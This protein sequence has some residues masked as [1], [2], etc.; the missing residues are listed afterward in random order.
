[1]KVINENE[2]SILDT[3][4]RDGCQ[5][6][7]MD[8]NVKKALRI[9][10]L[11]SRLGSRYIEMGFAGSNGSVNELI[12]QALKLK[13]G[14]TKIAA[15]GRT[16][17]PK[18]RVS[19]S[20]DLMS[21]L[22]LGV[23]VSVIVA[24][25]RLTDVKNSLGISGNENLQMIQDTILYLKKE[26]LEVIVDLEH[27]VDAYCGRGK[28]GQIEAGSSANEKYFL[29]VVKVVVDSGADIITIC[30]TNG[31]G[32][33]E[34]ASLMIDDLVSLYPG[35]NFG[36]HAHN[37]HDMAPAITRAAV[38]SGAKHI[39]GVFGGY[40]ERCG[41]A[42]LFSVIPRLQLKDGIEIVPDEALKIFTSAS[43][44][45]ARAFNRDASERAAFVGSNAF[46]TFAGMHG[47]SENKDKGAYTHSDPKLVGNNERIGVNK[48]SGKAN[49]YALAKKMGIKLTLDQVNQ[50]ILKH[51]KDIECGRFEASEESFLLACLELIESVLYFQIMQC[52]PS[53]VI[54]IFSGRED[55]ECVLK[56]MTEGSGDVRHEI[57]GGA[58]QFD[59]MFAVM[60]KSLSTDFPEVLDIALKSYSI[61]AFRV[62]QEGSGAFVRADLEFSA[63]GLTWNT[64]G[65]DRSSRR[66]DLQ[67]LVDGFKWFI[68][69]KRKG[70]Q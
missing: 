28:F 19:E 7:K 49:V 69:Q 48:N 45:I 8:I 2:V 56:I 25:S 53:S 11:L 21:I 27:A 31:G 23:P 55:S 57:E 35:M 39:Q 68:Y 40:G 70:E 62:E 61:N 65:V 30:D 41:N 52:K 3:L 67:A 6:K 24:K 51:G 66:A 50:F 33:P 20:R 15:F 32:S 10:E 59:A 12:K 38:L 46:T 47:D 37:D 42:N 43:A 18:E 16:R 54:D 9:V 63:N 22:S 26:G 58:G 1:M 17:K 44:Q 36:I 14:S 13:L 64:A 60:Q 4:F 29:D 34:E 5:G